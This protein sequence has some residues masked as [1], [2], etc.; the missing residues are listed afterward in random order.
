MRRITKSMMPKSLELFNKTS[1][2][3]WSD[4]HQPNNKKVYED[5]LDRCIIDQNNLCGYTEIALTPDTRHIDH[6][7]KRDFDP[8]LTFDWMNMIAAVKDS[9]FGADWKDN[10]IKK[11]D[12]DK[13]LHRYRNI[14]NPIE[15]EMNGRFT[16]FTD[17]TIELSD[18][19]DS[20]ASNTI[21]IFNLNESSLKSRRR[22][23]MQYVRNMAEGGIDK[24]SIL[25]Y[26]KQDGFISAIEYELSLI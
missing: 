2:A 5:C 13:N 20:T 21:K 25:S 15:D 26:L 24:D 4:I 16:F 18:S 14:L 23:I 19:N 7:I 17:G 8:R 9:R 3:D 6:Y 11:K 22:N 1:H 10:Q 12:Y